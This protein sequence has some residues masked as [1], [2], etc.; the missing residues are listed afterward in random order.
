MTG[1]NAKRDH[2]QVF[3]ENQGQLQVKMSLVLRKKK[4]KELEKH[5]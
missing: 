2:Y 3:L 4:K 1:C 5:K